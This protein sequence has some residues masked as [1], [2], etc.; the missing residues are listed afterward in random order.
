M[1]SGVVRACVCFARSFAYVPESADEAIAGL[2]QVVRERGPRAADEGSRWLHGLVHDGLFPRADYQRF[3]KAIADARPPTEKDL[4]LAELVQISNPAEARARL[5]ALLADGR[6][7]LLRAIF[8][9]LWSEPSYDSPDGN[10]LARVLG[11]LEEILPP[12]LDRGEVRYVRSTYLY[13]NE[14][15]EMALRAAMGV[16]EDLPGEARSLAFIK[17]M[18]READPMPE[19]GFFDRCFEEFRLEAPDRKTIR[20]LIADLGSPQ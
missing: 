15:T 8:G 7:P 1:Q 10:R 14:G 12:G 11:V 4:L 20:A 3:E 18:L 19:D 17:E 16:L 2:Q 6:M 9:D 13:F 5:E